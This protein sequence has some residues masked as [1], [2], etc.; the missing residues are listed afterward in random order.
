MNDRELVEKALAGDGD[1]WTAILTE[2]HGRV[3]NVC[4]RI[5][6]DPAL[7]EDMVQETMLVIFRKLDTF[8]FQSRLSTWI[9]RIAVNQCLMAI[10]A[11]K[12]KRSVP[13]DD[14]LAKQ[15]LKAALV[16]GSERPAALDRGFLLKETIAQLPAGYRNVLILHDI[17]GF[18]HEEVARLLG[19]SVG[20]SKSQLH[21]ARNK[22]QKLL[23]RKAN[24]RVFHPSYLAA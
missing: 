12:G 7:A 19:C 11:Q 8:E 18:E 2:N 4:F 23:N 24:P 20:T 15:R 10:R 9:H 14:E 5:L 16:P 3:K 21:K 17:E 1:A 6:F 13:L 22:M